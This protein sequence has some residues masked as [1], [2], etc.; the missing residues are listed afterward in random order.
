MPRYFFKVHD[1]TGLRDDRG[2]ELADRDA[3][4]AEA[5]VAAGEM[6]KETRR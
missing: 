3:A 1:G 5:I 2:T 4:H 6:L